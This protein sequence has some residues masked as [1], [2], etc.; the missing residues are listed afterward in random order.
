MELRFK[1]QFNRDLANANRKI[2]EQVRDCILN[3]KSAKSIAQ[4]AQLKKLRIYETHYRIKVAENYRIG[5]VIRNNV[6]WF[7]RF[8][9]RKNFYKSFP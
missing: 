2:S 6:V 8:G 1:S 4:I 3:V 9:H 5:I 7:A